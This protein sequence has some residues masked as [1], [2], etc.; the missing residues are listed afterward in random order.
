MIA[1]KSNIDGKPGI[2]STN[3]GTYAL[4]VA[5]NAYATVSWGGSDVRLKKQVQPLQNIL[6]K[7]NQL[8]PVSFAW[9][10]EEFPNKAFSKDPQIGLIA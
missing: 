4:Y 5:G 8:Q 3:P 1:A 10:N 9:R 2:G 6:E 7:I